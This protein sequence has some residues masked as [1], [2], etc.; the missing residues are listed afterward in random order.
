MSRGTNQDE[1]IKQMLYDK[2]TQRYDKMNENHETKKPKKKKKAKKANSN[3]TFGPEVQ[4]ALI[5]QTD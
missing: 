4:Q 3:P 2:S 1:Q 5:D